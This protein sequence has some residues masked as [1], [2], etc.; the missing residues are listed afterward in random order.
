MLVLDEYDRND[1]R[2]LMTET[3]GQLI[4]QFRRWQQFWLS[5]GCATF[6]LIKTLKYD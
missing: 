5:V 6:N 4:Q 1:G 2:F 3:T